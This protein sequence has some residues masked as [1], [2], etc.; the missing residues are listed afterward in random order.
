MDIG[1]QKHPVTPAVSLPP[2]GKTVFCLGFP[3]GA[4]CQPETVSYPSGSSPRRSRREG[5]GTALLQRRRCPE[6]CGMPSALVR[7]AGPDSP[8]GCGAGHRGPS[9]AAAS[10]SRESF[11]PGLASCGAARAEGRGAP[12]AENPPLPLELSPRPPALAGHALTCRR[13]ASPGR[14]A[15]SPETGTAGGAGGPRCPGPPSR[16]EEGNTRRRSPAEGQAPLTHQNGWE[17]RPREA[18][19]GGERRGA[20]RPLGE[21]G[22]C[23]HKGGQRA[24]G[25]RSPGG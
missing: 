19:G 15:A 21:R 8:P 6:G 5:T 11:S 25:A 24:A 23:A 20:D 10:L 13:S 16:P 9:A 18:G 12:P 4:R 7:G 14:P 2:S 17:E 22:G 1:Q 3:L